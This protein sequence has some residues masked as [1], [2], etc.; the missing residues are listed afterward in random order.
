M[1]GFPE[2]RSV[3]LSFQAADWIV[4][5]EAP[6]PIMPISEIFQAIEQ[7]AQAC[8]TRM[9]QIGI[10]DVKTE[11]VVEASLFCLLPGDGEDNR[12]MCIEC[13]CV[14]GRPANFI[15]YRVTQSSSL[16]SYKGLDFEVLACGCFEAEE[17][18]C[19]DSKGLI[20]WE[21]D[22]RRVRLP[23]HRLL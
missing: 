8:R 9:S 13:E 2:V 16:Y 14:V 7:L 12:H 18:K 4:H 21:D 6:P 22:R 3:C 20:L 17:P 19:E 15:K 11:V 23:L 10:D 1:T 5:E